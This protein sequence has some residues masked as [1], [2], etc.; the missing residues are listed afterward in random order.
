MWGGVGHAPELSWNSGYS[1]TYGYNRS[2]MEVALH[3]AKTGLGT[4]ETDNFE[5]IQREMYRKKRKFDVLKH[6]L[7]IGTVG[8]TVL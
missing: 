6:V 5:I 2:Y 4:E 8:C 3:V 1:V 7:Q